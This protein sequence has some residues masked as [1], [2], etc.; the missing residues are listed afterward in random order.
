[1]IFKF[2]TSINK[3]KNLGFILKYGINFRPFSKFPKLLPSIILNS[4]FVEAVT[5]SLLFFIW[6]DC[7]F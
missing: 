3:I 4:P 5:K 6:V 7:T 2:E 1:M